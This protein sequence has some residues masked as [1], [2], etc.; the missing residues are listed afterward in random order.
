M[1]S[2]QSYQEG[3]HHPWPPTNSNQCETSPAKYSIAKPQWKHNHGERSTAEDEFYKLGKR[4]VNEVIQINDPFIAKNEPRE[5]QITSFIVARVRRCAYPVRAHQFP[6]PEPVLL[7]TKSFHAKEGLCSIPSTCKSTTH[8]MS[9]RCVVFR[10]LV[11]YS[12]CLHLPHAIQDRQNQP[13]RRDWIWQC[14]CT[15]LLGSQ[16]IGAT[17]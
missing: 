11:Q 17:I 13:S 1:K 8:P 7:C 3:T 12:M 9:E 6:A 2:S 5:G 15:W 14:S 4:F 10:P 16:R